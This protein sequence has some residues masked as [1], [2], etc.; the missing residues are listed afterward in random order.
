M[1]KF[2][3]REGPI[4][5]WLKRQRA[6]GARVPGATEVPAPSKGR[7][8]LERHTVLDRIELFTAARV[9]R[10]LR[11]DAERKLTWLKWRRNRVTAKLRD[12]VERAARLTEEHELVKQARAVVLK[13][14]E[15]FGE[16]IV[17]RNGRWLTLILPGI[18]FAG[19]W[20]LATMAFSFFAGSKADPFNKTFGIDRSIVAGFVIELALAGLAKVAGLNLAW[21][22]VPKIGRLD[23]T[24]AAKHASEPLVYDQWPKAVRWAA[25]AFAVAVAFAGLYAIAKLRMVA[26]GIFS[27]GNEPT[28][29]AVT[30]LGGGSPTAQRVSVSMFLALEAVPFV[31]Q[32]L[33]AWVVTT[34][35]ADALGKLEKGEQKKAGAIAAATKRLNRLRAKWHTLTRR[36]V[37]L[38]LITGV[39]QQ[40]AELDALERSEHHVGGNPQ[41]YGVTSN[42]RDMDEHLKVE[43]FQATVEGESEDLPLPDGL[44]E[45][46]SSATEDEQTPA[47]DDRAIEPYDPPRH[48]P[49]SQERA[50]SRANGSGE[51]PQ[52]DQ[53]EE[54]A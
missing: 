18:L 49:Q 52:G 33:V 22:L 42:R 7:R 37:A 32:V 10:L 50:D 53:A 9:K 35:L 48:D 38:E 25:A 45:P 24:D 8:D 39:L 6:K 44:R 36:I 21:A 26:T 29:G 20:G 2:V 47:S 41:V 12:T 13:R 14:I 43:P 16:F 46:A 11:V 31:L 17:R 5:A 34:P 51:L 4:R 28:S 30:S 3:K 27:G 1:L 40:V 19:G 15:P 54:A 23:K